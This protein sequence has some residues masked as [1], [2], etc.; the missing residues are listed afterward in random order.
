MAGA[1][2]RAEEG[3]IFESFPE[4]NVSVG[5]IMAILAAVCAIGVP[6]I[7]LV[8]LIVRSGEPK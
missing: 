3:R 7:E 4:I 8:E 1:S 2:T 6:L 5:M